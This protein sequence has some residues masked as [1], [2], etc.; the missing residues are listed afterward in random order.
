M[1]DQLR[2]AFADEIRKMQQGVRRLNVELVAAEGKH[3]RTFYRVQLVGASNAQIGTIVSEGEHRCIALAGFLSEL[4]TEPTKSTVVFDD[5]VTSLDHHWR[6]CFAHRLVEE[7]ADRQVIVFT[8]DLV[9]LHDLLDGASERSLPVQIQQLEARR[10]T[11]GI[12]DEGLPWD[13]R[14]VASRLD[15]LEKDIRTAR[16]LYENHEDEPY[17]AK[18][19]GVYGRL[20]ATIEKVV[21]EQIF[22]RVVVRHRD[23][24]NLK[25]LPKTVA[26][27]SDHCTRIKNLFSKCCDIT[28]AHHRSPS[29]GFSV[30]A[31]ADVLNDVAELKSIVD[32]VKLEQ[33]NLC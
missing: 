15:T 6:G 16:T 31:P 8:H 2:N 24:I 10:A 21:E 9:F 13:A 30:P 12:V 3:G 1:T 25:E 23:Y 4:A 5:P 22:C 27:T 14:S 11:A 20:R 26:V 19:E 7:S 33:K 18:I 29:R 17:K 32:A 28:D